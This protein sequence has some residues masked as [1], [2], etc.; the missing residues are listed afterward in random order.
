M[1]FRIDNLNLEI[2]FWEPPAFRHDG[3]LEFLIFRPLMTSERRCVG[4]VVVDGD[5]TVDA[6]GVIVGGVAGLNRPRQ[7]RAGC[8]GRWGGDRD[9]G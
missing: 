8:V 7:R 2:R 3:E 9:R 4:G 5:S 6:T 1:G